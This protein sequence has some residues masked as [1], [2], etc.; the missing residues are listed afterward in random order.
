MSPTT[1]DRLK[2]LPLTI[3]LTVLIWMY[4]EAKF[5]TTGDARV[6]VR[7]VS[8]N[9]DLV[10]RL[11]DPTE[12]RFLPTASVVVSV[13]GPTNQITTVQQE[14]EPPTLTFVPQAAALK[15]GAE[16]YV[17][18]ASMLNSLSYFKKRGLT[19][20]SA[21]PSRIRLE[22]DHVEQVSR[23]VDF[24]PAVAVEHM[25]G[26]PDQATVL[27]PARTL[28]EIGG[29]D[30]ITVAAVPTR[31]LSTL[32]IGTQQTV[33]VR[34]VPEYPGAR[35]ERVAV[36][37]AQGTVT[38]TVPKREAITQAVPDVP[39][40][41]SGPPAL[42][43]R[44]DVDVKPKFISVTVSGTEPAIRGLKDKLTNSSRGT[45]GGDEGIHAYL[46]VSLEDRP[47]SSYTRRHVRYVLPDGLTVQDAP[48][49]VEFRLVEITASQAPDDSANSARPS[50]SPR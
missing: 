15:I 7:P 2:S 19:V 10:L 41:V 13:S 27:I 33:V 32:P 8:P 44:Y 46:D 48:T 12:A 42:L 38:L 37:P 36:T 28:Q 22:A 21:M 39:V 31:D 26:L 50:P 24:R 34:F 29:P 16:N 6:S 23:P 5:T 49:D 25:S 20:T 4:A 11:F 17:D 9:G 3:V 35:D 40:W 30:K 1:V 45:G 18:T 43:A 47:A 14:P